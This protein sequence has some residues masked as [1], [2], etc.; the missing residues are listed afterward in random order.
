VSACEGMLLKRMW[1]HIEDCVCPAEDPKRFCASA[2]VRSP[3]QTVLPVTL[4]HFT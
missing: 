3:E 2:E 4:S 1:M